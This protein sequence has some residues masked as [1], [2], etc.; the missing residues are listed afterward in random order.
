MPA[1]ELRQTKTII[2]RYISWMVSLWNLTDAEIS[3]NHSQSKVEPWDIVKTT[4]TI[5]AE[6]ACHPW[7]SIEV[8][9]WTQSWVNTMQ[10]KLN[11]WNSQRI[12]S[13]TWKYLNRKSRLN[14]NRKT[15]RKMVDL[16]SKN[17]SAQQP[18]HGSI[19]N[20]NVGLDRRFSMR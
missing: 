8:L 1:W 4:G 11:L 17:R 13:I 3:W 9:I 2:S 15:P 20:W 18:V 7:A 10:V 12:N 5:V 16:P 6:L 19:S 14:R